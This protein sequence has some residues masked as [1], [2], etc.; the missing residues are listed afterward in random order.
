MLLFHEG[1]GHGIDL[2]DAAIQ[3]DGG[4][5]TMGE[6]VASNAAA[7]DFHVQPPESGA[8]LGYIL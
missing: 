3:P 1:F 6:Q 4:I 5:D 2:A 7:G 8:A